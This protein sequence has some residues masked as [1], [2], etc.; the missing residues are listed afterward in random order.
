MEKDLSLLI[1]CERGFYDFITFSIFRI[2]NVG[3]EDFS[4]P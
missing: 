3:S 2:P 4:D 1:L